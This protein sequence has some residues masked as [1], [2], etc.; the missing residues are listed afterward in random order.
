MGFKEV[1]LFC[2]TTFKQVIYRLGKA[3]TLKAE[4]YPLVSINI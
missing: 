2:F 4:L 1:K 3:G